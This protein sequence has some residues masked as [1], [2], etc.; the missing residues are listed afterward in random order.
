MNNT[1]H[2]T[3]LNSR[4][5]HTALATIGFMLAGT[6][7]MFPVATA[8]QWQNHIEHRSSLVFEKTI[9]SELDI[10]VRT[11]KEHLEN[12]RVILNPPITELAILFNVSR[13][14]IYKWLAQDSHP[15]I[16]KLELITTLSKIADIFREAGILRAG[17]LLNMKNS[18]G[19][20]LLDLLKTKQ[21][22][23]EHIRMLI[24][25]AKI[26]EASYQRSGLAESNAKPTNDWV[27]SISI[28]AYPKDL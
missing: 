22:Y 12:I 19:I 20:S 9:P 13:Q 26:M 21:P 10:D 4:S 6:G 27:S 23:E 11:P 3:F 5:R 24:T 8:S 28:P 1:G 7:S 17:I 25:E 14:A 2:T 18:E 16:E 15:E